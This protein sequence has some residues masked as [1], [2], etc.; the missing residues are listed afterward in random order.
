MDENF[1]T[2]MK[3]LRKS[4]KLTQE[5]LGEKIGLQ[6]SAISKY[7]SGAIDPIL[8]TARR[9]ADALGVTTDFLLHGERSCGVWK[10]DLENFPVCSVC[11]E[12][13]LERMIFGFSENEYHIKFELSNYCPSCGA[14]MEAKA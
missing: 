13:A 10:F 7:E 2:R 6:H 5:Q 1:G 8:P 4:M 11:G 14:K 12:I 9:I 3:Q